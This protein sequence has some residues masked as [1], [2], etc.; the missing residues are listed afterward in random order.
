MI[1]GGENYA[2]EKNYETFIIDA[3][4]TCD[5]ISRCQF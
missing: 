1:F 4:G 2:K 3:D 5:V